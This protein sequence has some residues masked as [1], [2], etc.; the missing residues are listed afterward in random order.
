MNVVKKFASSLFVDLRVN[1][2][3]N[4]KFQ[5]S[6]NVDRRRRRLSL[7]RNFVRSGGFEHGDVEDWVYTSH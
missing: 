1:D 2:F 3:G 5:F 4:F 6:V 7:V